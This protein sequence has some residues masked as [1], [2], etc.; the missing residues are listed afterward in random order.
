M[1][2]VYATAA[3]SPAEAR[4]LL[5]RLPLWRQE[6]ARRLNNEN[7]FRLSVS[8]GALWAHAL[9]TQGED[10]ARPVTLLAAGKPVFSRGGPFFSLSHS[11]EL[12]LCALSPKPIG[13][14]VQELRP[15]KL[16][17]ARRFCPGEYA[18]LQALPES[19]QT[20]ALLALWARKEAWVKAESRERMLRLDEYNVLEPGRWHFSDFRL[21]GG[22]FCSVCAE[23]AAPEPLIIEKAIFE[24]II[25]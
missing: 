4:A 9:R 16:S 8:A 15:A 13:A 5:P 25:F 2:R 20:E 7:A 10:P 11:G 22:S 6:K 21:P 23:T 1:I 17:L 19:A 3:L 18:R 24:H 14:D 12:V